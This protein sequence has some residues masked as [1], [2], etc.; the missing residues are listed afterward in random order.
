MS[1]GGIRAGG[2]H[3]PGMD[4]VSDASSTASGAPAA[5]SS[6]AFCGDA[7][8]EA[9]ARGERT[10]ASGSKGDAV[11]KFQQRLITTGYPLPKY[12][13]NGGYGGEGMAA[14]KKLQRD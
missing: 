1:V 4:G 6:A 14:V 11:K 12:G 10:I 8:F 9:I 5:L 13:A 7:D 2:A 3:D